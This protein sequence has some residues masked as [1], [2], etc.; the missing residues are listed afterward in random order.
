MPS[1]LSSPLPRAL[2]RKSYWVSQSRPAATPKAMRWS[3]LLGRLSKM[4]WTP[5]QSVSPLLRYSSLYSAAVSTANQLRVIL[6]WVGHSAMNP[7]GAGVSVRVRSFTTLE[8]A[9]VFL[10]L[11]T[12]TRYTTSVSGG[13]STD[14]KKIALPGSVSTVSHTGAL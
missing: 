7:L 3:D 1:F 9:T 13:S 11:I 12:R 6:V 8:S 4:P 10:E 14:V 5:A 2:T